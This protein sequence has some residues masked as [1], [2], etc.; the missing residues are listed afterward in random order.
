MNG[1]NPDTLCVGELMD[2][3]FSGKLLRGVSLNPERFALMGYSSG[4][5]WV[6]RMINEWTG[7]RTSSGLTMPP[8]RAA[9]IV[10]AGSYQCF[11]QEEPSCWPC[12][13]PKNR[14]EARYDSGQIPWTLH[15]PTLLVQA[16]EDPDTDKRAA[17]KYFNVLARHAATGYLLYDKGTNHGPNPCHVAPMFSFLEH[18]LK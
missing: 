11:Q 7:M 8:I 4:G 13:C 6:S 5:H 14:S 12:S 2:L 17:S 15:P 3:V 18:A 9:L 10:A 16:L 1:D